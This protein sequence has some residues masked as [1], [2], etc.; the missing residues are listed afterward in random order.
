[1]TTRLAAQSAGWDESD[2]ERRRA[3]TREPDAAPQG[4]LLRHL[5]RPDRPDGRDGRR[6]VQRFDDEWSTSA[7][8]LA[9]A[10]VKATLWRGSSC[11]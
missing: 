3:G 10:S 7:S 9:I 1:M 4:Q 5:L 11:T 2:A 8:R 6:G